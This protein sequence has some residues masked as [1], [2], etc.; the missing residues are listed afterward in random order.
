MGSESHL[1]DLL[2]CAQHRSHILSVF[3]QWSFAP[4]LTKLS[5]TV[6]EVK[7]GTG[8]P[9]LT[10]WDVNNK[11][12]DSSA[13]SI[14]L[15]LFWVWNNSYLSSMWKIKKQ[16]KVISVEDFSIPGIQWHLNFFKGSSN[17][18]HSFSEV[19][20]MKLYIIIKFSHWDTINNTGKVELLWWNL[21]GRFWGTPQY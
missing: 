4:W 17:K 5:T 15:Y 10:H 20:S 19:L 12:R 9:I 11:W 14:T 21:I 6:V 3:S 13:I 18:I 8:K 7:V 1:K 16:F 2:T